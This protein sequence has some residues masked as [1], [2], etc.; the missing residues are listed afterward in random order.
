MTTTVTSTIKTAGG[1]YSSLSAW[2]AAKQADIVAAD[3]IQQAECYDGAFN[4]LTGI[5][6]WTTSATNYI[7]I[8]TPTAERHNGTSRDVSGVG[9]Q[10]TYDG[11]TT[12]DSVLY[13]SEDYVRLEGLEIKNTAASGGPSRR[14]ALI[15]D[16]A[17]TGAGLNQLLLQDCIFI[18]GVGSNVPAVWLDQGALN[19]ILRNCIIIVRGNS[20]GIGNFDGTSGTLEVS[21]CTILDQGSGTYG[22]V[23]QSQGTVKNTYAGGFGTED[24]YT[25]GVAPTG[26]HNASSDTSASTDFTSSLTSKAASNQFVSVTSGSEDLHLKSGS[27]LEAAGT[28]LGAVTTDIDGDARSGTTPDIGAD[29]FGGTTA[30]VGTITGTGS[31]AAIG[32]STFAAAGT[33][34]GTGTLAAVGASTAEAAASATGT[35]TL[36]A[37]GASTAAA[38]GVFSGTGTLEAAAAYTAEAV[39]TF[40]GSG[41]LTA[42]SP[43]A[44]TATGGRGRTIITPDGRR[45]KTRDKREYNRALTEILRAEVPEAIEETV[46]PVTSKKAKSIGRTE[47]VRTIRPEILAEIERAQANL[48]ATEAAKAI[49]DA[50]LFVARLNAE[51]TAAMQEEEAL[52]TIL[53]L[54]A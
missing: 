28:P 30:G 14:G 36:S 29:E 48:A 39:A 3:E 4:G 45:I 50:R 32:A 5:V 41:T 22:L 2:E 11:S 15:V 34:S 24:F 42:F 27:D 25:G 20:Q 10:F 19:A 1:D 53:A 16:T 51:A 17:P 6:G 37:V 8:Y 9:A 54:A 43:V 33:A 7:R 49:A 21:H 26:S 47:I 31:L 12:D 52:I 46:R 38:A 18:D 35:G 13:I 40:S 44:D 23:T